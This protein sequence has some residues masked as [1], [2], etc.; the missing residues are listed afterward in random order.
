MSEYRVQWSICLADKTPPS[1]ISR[2]G[3][4]ANVFG[5]LGAALV[6]GGLFWRHLSYLKEVRQKKE[7]QN[8]VL[9]DLLDVG[10]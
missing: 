9:T 4:A 1:L 3:D 2:L 6:C 8:S 7:K 10:N 5:V